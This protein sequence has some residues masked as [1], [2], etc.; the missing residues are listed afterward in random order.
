MAWHQPS[1][2]DLVLCANCHGKLHWDENKK[3]ARCDG[4]TM[5]FQTVSESSIL[6]ARTDL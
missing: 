4:R 2:Q 3:R 6:S 1:K 5:V